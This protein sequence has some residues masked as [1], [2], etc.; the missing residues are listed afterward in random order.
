M[1]YIQSCENEYVLHG[2]MPENQ[3][4]RNGD[5]LDKIGQQ[6]KIYMLMNWPKSEAAEV[7]AG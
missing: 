1:P 6:A 3:K 5:T 7:S 4:L 2:I